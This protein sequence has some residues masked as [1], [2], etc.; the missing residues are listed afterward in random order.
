MCVY[1]LYEF[2]DCRNIFLCE[3]LI[4]AVFQFEHIDSISVAILSAMIA[5]EMH[6]EPEDSQSLIA[7]SLLY[8]FGYL[9]VPKSICSWQSGGQICPQPSIYRSEAEPVVLE[10]LG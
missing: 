3:K 6:I 4:H 8:D 10:V 9:S 5:N 1:I 2:R 7:A